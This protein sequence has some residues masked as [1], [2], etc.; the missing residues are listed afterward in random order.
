MSELAIGERPLRIEDVVSVARGECKVRM[1]SAP[2]FV[3][4]IERGAEIIQRRVRDNVPT[5]GVNTGFGASVKNTVPMAQALTLAAH[6]PR[7]HGCGVGPLLSEEESRAVTLVRLVSLSA[8][9]SGV[10]LQLLEHL[11]QL[12]RAGVTPA[13]PARGSVG[14]SG[15]L[16][17]L[18]Y[19][20]ALLM[21][22]RSAFLR[23]QLVDSSVALAAAGLQPLVLQPKES[24][25]I[26]N[27]TS[28]MAGLSCLSFARAERIARTA[29]L[30][31]A[32]VIEAM[33]A[34]RAH[35]DA[36]LFQ[37]KAHPGQAA[38]AGWIRDA[39]GVSDIPELRTGRIQERYSLRCAPHVI[40]VL[41]DALAFSRPVLEIEINGASDNPL[42]DPETGDV[43]HGGNFYGGHV[44]M[45]ADTLKTQV[46]NV[47]DLLDRQLVLL[48]DPQQNGGLPENLN[49]VTGEERHAHHGFKAMEIT[50]SALTA[51]ALKLTMPASVFSRSTEG[52]NQDKVS[53][54]SIAAQDFQQ[55]ATLTEHVVAVHLIACA[56]AVE[57]RGVERVSPR[58]AQLHRRVREHI[59]PTLRDRPMDGDIIK[60]VELVRAGAV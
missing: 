23:G 57:L 21:G 17:P 8:G 49:A 52:H 32:A 15:D 46:A 1:S 5:Y 6:L 14:A 25:A 40:G 50:A 35:F 43:L 45:V 33:A 27:G 31:T 28:I 53:M 54:G 24:L 60:A 48:N 58:I 59:A 11:A 30:L 19:I 16:T 44:A 2:A 38:C 36:R 7:Y 56:Q 26:M 22:E 12:L 3:A 34:Q 20:A 42:I 39:L 41:V 9:Y 47:A 13:I 10:R 4:R 37:A 55:I 29:A 18:S 51:E